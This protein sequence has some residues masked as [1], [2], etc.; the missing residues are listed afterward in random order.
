MIKNSEHHEID[1]LFK[2]KLENLD[3]GAQ[4]HLWERV[5]TELDKN[6]KSS[7]ILAFGWF[8]KLFVLFT[9]L[10]FSAILAYKF[11]FKEEKKSL[12]KPSEK[13]LILS[14][15]SIEI[16]N[17][18]SKAKINQEFNENL[19][20]TDISNSSSFKIRANN[21]T[22]NLNKKAQT[23]DNQQIILKN[24]NNISEK[25]FILT[26]SK[27]DQKIAQFPLNSNVNL[28]ISNPSEEGC[29]NEHVTYS[30]ALNVSSLAIQEK[31]SLFNFEFIKPTTINSFL[32]QS[33]AKA[34]R[35]KRD[36][37][38][39]CFQ[40]NISPLSH[41]ALDAYYS[42][43][44]SMRTMV[45]KDEP[46][47]LY[48]QKRAGS[49]SYVGA[50]S[51][52]FR[53]SYVNKQGIAIRTGINFCK[54]K[55]RFEFLSR[56]DSGWVFHTYPVGSGKPK[57]STW[58]AMNVIEKRYNTYKFL[59]VPIIL[60]YEIDLADFVFSLNAGLG[61]N[62]SSSYAG[63]VYSKDLVTTIDLS[64]AKSDVSSENYF[65]QKIGISII[66]SFGLNYK[67]NRKLMLLAEPTIRYY[68]KPI[69]SSSYPIDQKYLQ[70]GISTGL[71]YRIF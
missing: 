47:I 9:L 63:K 35:R 20:E 3:L 56:S 36:V 51:F 40:R 37:N 27:S 44:I 53:A 23:T 2:K 15:T 65:K 32:I 11:G 18:D 21:I 64:S 33:K 69:T 17:I 50:S 26:N 68:M 39:D 46:S 52:G 34:K 42:P 67:I 8:T 28:R 41:F 16:A 58:V 10:S 7:R 14:E 66:G 25:S 43:E 38:D 61:F 62:I 1:K 6:K 55:E 48:T 13:T 71:R 57:D 24:K 12:E 30:E 49:E 54:I 70:L 60:G 29:G 22:F 19:N 5:K 59:D 45:A 31:R 4:A